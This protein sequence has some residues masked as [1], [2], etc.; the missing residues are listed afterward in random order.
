M[1]FLNFQA[2]LQ[3]NGI[4]ITFVPARAEHA[5]QR[6]D[7]NPERVLFEKMMRAHADN[8]GRLSRNM[9][10]GAMGGDE[11]L[12][13][14][15]PGPWSNT[16]SK[17]LYDPILGLDF[18][19]ADLAGVEIAI[20]AENPD[21]VVATANMM[22]M[23]K[24]FELRGKLRRLAVAAQS[25]LTASSALVETQVAARDALFVSTKDAIKTLEEA[26][27]TRAAIEAY[28]AEGEPNNDNDDAIG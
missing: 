24:A 26:Y 11:E 18:S 4:R 9:M 10:V 6:G 17:E 19:V 28:L 12:S 16:P 8:L 15:S 2:M 5:A 1:N 21:L 7:I 14:T 13:L 3:D 23:A 27:P 20:T 22:L 25:L